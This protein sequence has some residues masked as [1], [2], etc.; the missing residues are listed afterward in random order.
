MRYK[1]TKQYA[2]D[3]E[4]L[5]AEFQGIEDAKFFLERKNIADSEKNIKL[6]YRLFD[7]QTLIN[8]FN[9]EKM[10]SLIRPGT[11]AEG[12]NFL[13][14]SFGHYKISKDNLV[15]HAH[16]GFTELN[17]AELF[18]EDKLT[19]STIMTTY[20]IFN[21]DEKI[22][23]LNQH[24]KKLKESEGGSQGKSETASFRPTPFNTSPR[25]QGIPPTSV[26]DEKDEKDEKK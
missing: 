15:A 20:Y 11:Y 23:E 10:N 25:P 4:K 6:I 18:V 24:V 12:D 22:A 1:I 7:D 3:T 21:N 17:D 8:E 13:P 2:Q 14:D 9:K 19:H 16:A 5:I 26:K